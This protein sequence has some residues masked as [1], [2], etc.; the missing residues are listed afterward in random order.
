[1]A[2][3]ALGCRRL[4]WVGGLNRCGC[5]GGVPGT[6]L[7]GLA[8]GDIVIYGDGVLGYSSICM[9]TNGAGSSSNPKCGGGVGARSDGVNYMVTNSFASGAVGG[10]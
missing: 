5:A 7:L 2:R 10:G 9:S 4:A 6:T 3:L 8:L 1:M